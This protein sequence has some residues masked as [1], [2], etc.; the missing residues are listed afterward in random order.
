MSKRYSERLIETFHDHDLSK[1][2]ED[3]LHGRSGTMSRIPR[4][5]PGDESLP[6]YRSAHGGAN[7]LR[8]RAC[9][10]PQIKAFATM[11]AQGT[12]TAASMKGF[13]FKHSYQKTWRQTEMAKMCAPPSKKAFWPALLLLAIAA[14]GAFSVQ[15]DCW[16]TAV[17]GRVMVFFFLLGWLGLYL[18][19]YH[20]YWNLRHFPQRMSEYHRLHYCPRCS[21]VTR[22]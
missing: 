17:C 6:M 12:S 11:Y 4:Q 3:G 2:N 22:V 16:P 10:N 21:T 19:A 8:C 14:G 5:C 13:L 20:L 9:C 15:A 18:G 7:P 1:L